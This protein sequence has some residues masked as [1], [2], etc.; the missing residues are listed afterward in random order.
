MALVEDFRIQF[1]A[2]VLG[3]QRGEVSLFQEQ[4]EAATKKWLK[5]IFSVMASAIRRLPVSDAVYD[6]GPNPFGYKST[7]PTTYKW[8]ERKFKKLAAHQKDYG[9]PVPALWRGISR[10][11][12]GKTSLVELLDKLG[13]K[14]S[15]GPKLFDA[16]GGA[17]LPEQFSGQKAFAQKYFR[18]SGFTGKAYNTRTQANMS[19]RSAVDPEVN[20]LLREGAR[21]VVPGSGARING[22]NTVSVAGRSGTISMQRAVVEGLVQAGISISYLAK[23]DSFRGPG[24]GEDELAVILNQIGLLDDK[25]TK[26]LGWLHKYG[27]GVMTPMMGAQMFGPGNE[28]LQSYLKKSRVL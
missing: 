24:A 27:H 9:G 1:E 7:K 23:L 18:Q 20:R 13:R 16:L 21:K 26:K 12:P 10:V 15:V 25:N 22:N 11:Q 2:L 14:R 19:W 17:T 4:V 6:Y 28:T 5:N 8:Q 3:M